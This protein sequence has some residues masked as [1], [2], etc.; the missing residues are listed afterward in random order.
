MQFA[1]EPLAI[2]SI[3]FKKGDKSTVTATQTIALVRHPRF[4]RGTKPPGD[5][6]PDGLRPEGSPF[7]ETDFLA[8]LVQD[9]MARRVPQ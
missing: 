9:E 5:R 6:V 4:A 1:T 2:G 3:E 7:G 8:L